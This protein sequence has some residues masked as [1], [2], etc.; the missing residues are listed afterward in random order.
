M[1]VTVLIAAVSVATGVLAAPAGAPG[2]QTSVSTSS[3][4]FI[5]DTTT[6]SSTGPAFVD[7][8]PVPISDATFAALMAGNSTF[9]VPTSA[10]SSVA[11][12]FGDSSVVPI[13]TVPSAAPTSSESPFVPTSALPSAVSTFSDSPPAIPFIRSVEV[14]GAGKAG[15]A[16]PPPSSYPALRPYP[17]PSGPYPGPPGPYPGPRG[18]YLPGPYYYGGYPSYYYY[19]Y[20]AYTYEYTYPIPASA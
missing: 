18:P 5:N 19:T 12:T 2:P 8:L 14:N 15:A 1:K 7:S 11:S 9:V 6:A 4:S 3:N 16:Y 13:A 10:V 20:P 17:G